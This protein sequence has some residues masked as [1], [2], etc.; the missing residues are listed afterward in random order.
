MLF[1]YKAIKNDKLVVE[2][3]QADSQDAVLRF[4]KTNN[5]FPIAI[6]KAELA[7]LPIFSFF[8]R[9][10]FSDVVDFT[11]QLAIML[12]A[13]LTLIDALEILK[14]QVTKPEYLAVLENLEKEIK[15]GKNF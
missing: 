13:G 10:T 3:I 12:D 7:A 15:S 9:L 4:L 2:K 6:W 8:R 5:Y 1:K 11:R 14:K